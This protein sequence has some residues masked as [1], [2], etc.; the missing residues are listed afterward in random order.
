M[1][2]NRAIDGLHRA[3]HRALVA[4]LIRI[5]GGFEAAEDV[6]QDT[7]AKALEVWGREGLPEVP[8]AWLR[9]TARNGAIDRYRR[10]GR[11][12]QKAAQIAAEAPAQVM[13]RALDDAFE[14]AHLADDA[15]R[16]IFTCCHPALAPE[17]Q[18]GLTLRTVC[19]LTSEQVARAF[20][21]QRTTLQQRLV[22]A[23]RKIDQ[24]GIRYEVPGPEQL[25]PRLAAVLHTVYLVFTEGYAATDGDTLLRVDL[26]DEAIRLARLVSGLLPERAEVQGL[27][28]LMLLHHARRAARVD[29]AG[30]LV[31]LADQD[32]GRWDRA[33]IAEALPLVEAG[34]RGRPT[35]TYAIEAAIAAL[36]ARA[37]SAADTDWMQIAALYA[38]LERQTG[39][40]PVVRLNAAVAVAM[41]GGLDAGLAR[42]EALAG[43]PALATSHRLPAARAELLRRAGRLT[44]AR[45]AFREALAR[46]NNPVEARHLARRLAALG[47]HAA[48]E[49]EK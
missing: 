27:L 20:L 15:L 6:V 42:L 5:L 41:A 46:V 45:A 28:A 22:R 34:L 9:R 21:V 14:D 3:H 16:L 1:D 49:R 17:A 48:E 18:I 32:R 29:D 39:G 13:A 2:L 19:G 47:G 7:F 12:R 10:Q 35:A 44:D 26:C 4:P 43:E 8:L 40:N 11:W 24:A 31:L 37:P 25:E 23:Q 30:E 36:H 33:L 38:V